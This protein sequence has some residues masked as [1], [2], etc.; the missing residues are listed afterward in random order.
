MSYARS[1]LW[2]G[3]SGVGTFVVLATAL[4]LTDVPGRLL[5]GMGG[6]WLQDVTSLAGLLG[7]IA[8]LVLPFDLLGGLVLPRRHGRPAPDLPSFLVSWLRG[9][10]AL[11]ALCSLSGSLLIQGGQLGGRPAALA[12][13]VLLSLV[14]LACQRPIAGVVGGL[15][16]AD[17]KSLPGA[18]L[19][20]SDDPAFSGGFSGFPA[21]PVLPRAWMERLGREKVTLLLR[22]RQSILSS[23]AWT[24]GII[25]ALGWNGLGF[26]LASLL[27]G[28][29]VTSIAELASTALGFTIWG[30]IGLLYLPTPSRRATLSADMGVAG[31]DPR[32]RELLGE[33]ISELDRLQDDE[34]ERSAGV[35]RIFH[36]VPSVH[37]RQS[38]LQ[39]EPAEVSGGAA[40][41]LARTALY[42]SHAGL[43]LLP[44]VV[45]CNVGRPQLWIY[46]PA[47]G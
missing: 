19:V 29:G 22:R 16:G 7:G 4:L 38:A 30:F 45:H 11:V 31:S 9:A 47:D 34:P 15:R 46:L 24:R 35:E 17:R 37:R 6:S 25:L 13:L 33:V 41:H 3:I 43:S 8:L 1:R 18:V 36:P 23:G 2:T 12:V 32:E 40:W 14:L 42:L 28:A 39:G 10:V 27:P 20:D 26:L 21:R 5:S 44:R